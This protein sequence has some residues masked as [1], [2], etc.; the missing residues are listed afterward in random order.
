M[1]KILQ[2][3]FPNKIELPLILY[4]DD[5]VVGNYLESHTGINKLCGIYFSLACLPPEYSSR[6]ENMFLTQLSDASYMKQFGNRAIYYHI[7]NE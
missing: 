2:H 1:E 7:V 5:F 6:L 4:S 3:S